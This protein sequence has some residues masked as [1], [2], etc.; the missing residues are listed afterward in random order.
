[1]RYHLTSLTWNYLFTSWHSLETAYFH[2]QIQ[3]SNGILDLQLKLID[4]IMSVLKQV[5]LLSC[6]WGR[7]VFDQFICRLE[8]QLDYKR[9]VE[10]IFPFQ[11]GLYLTHSSWRAS[12]GICGMTDIGNSSN[13]VE[14]LGLRVVNMSEYLLPV[15]IPK[16][17]IYTSLIQEIMWLCL[18]SASRAT[19]VFV[20]L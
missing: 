16:R 10:A 20:L 6:C 1:M 2:I 15:E 3:H 7:S 13:W 8:F 11:P 14:G 17:S 19:C 18:M 5:I 12:M 4:E 9:Q